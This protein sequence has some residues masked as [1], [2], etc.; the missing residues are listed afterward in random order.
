MC[1]PR[2]TPKWSSAREASEHGNGHEKHC[3]QTQQGT[4]HEESFMHRHF[5]MVFQKTSQ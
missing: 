1:S 5:E 4:C 3:P 2:T